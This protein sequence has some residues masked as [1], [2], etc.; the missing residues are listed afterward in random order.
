LTRKGLDMFGTH[1]RS[2]PRDVGQSLARLA[3]Q[4]LYCYRRVLGAPGLDNDP[5]I[6]V[7]PLLH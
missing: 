2:K 6:R 1:F 5:H 3:R 7:R 4:L